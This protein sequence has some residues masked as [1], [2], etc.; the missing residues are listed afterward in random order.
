MNF[1]IRRAQHSD[2]QGIID[3]HVKSIREVCGKDYTPEQIEAWAGRRF[4]TEL[5]HQAI[6]RDYIWV[7][8]ADKSILGFGHFAV[9]DENNGEVLGLYFIPPVI[10]NGCGR[11]MFAEF[12][13]VA[14]EHNLTKINLHSTITAKSFYE[15]LGFHQNGSDTTIE[16]RGIA[17]PCYPMEFDL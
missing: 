8:E 15:S 9:M 5:W 4:K 3:V 1:K 13:K 7:I 17:I 6:D 11:K 14:K 16:M 12:V 10:G 2:S